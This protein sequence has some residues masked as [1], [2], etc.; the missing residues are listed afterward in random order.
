M[1]KRPCSSGP[2]RKELSCCTAIKNALRDGV[3]LC[4]RGIARGADEGADLTKILPAW[5]RLDAGRD[6][7]AR[8]VRDAQ[9]FGHIGGVEPAR[10]HERH[11]SADMLQKVPIKGLP[12]PAQI[13]RA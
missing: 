13:G 3:D 5:R 4:R 9:G 10:Q 8:S 11:V 12:E 2:V 6:V 7:D 1:P